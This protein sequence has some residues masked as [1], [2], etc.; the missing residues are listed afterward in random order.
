MCVQ[1]GYRILLTK[2]AF[3]SLE[4]T[5]AELFLYLSDLFSEDDERVD[6]RRVAKVTIADR[7]PSSGGGAVHRDWTHGSI[8]DVKTG[9]GWVQF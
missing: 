6:E 2:Y 4:I 1:S 7:G 3:T 5:F 8:S 9:P